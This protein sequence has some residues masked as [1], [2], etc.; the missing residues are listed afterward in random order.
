M[1]SMDPIQ[2]VLEILRRAPMTGTNKLGLLL[3]LLDLAHRQTHSNP[4]ISIE[5]LS[6][7]YLALHWEHGRPYAQ[8]P[9]RQTYARSRSSEPNAPFD[10]TVMQQ[11]YH[12]RKI[13]VDGGM[14]DLQNRNFEVVRLGMDKAEWKD[15]WEMEIR[16]S[17][18]KIAR[19]VWRNPV[20]RL[21]NLPGG[22][23]PFLF[24]TL[25]NTIKFLP[26]VATEL[27]RF[28]GVLRPLIELQFARVVG[29]INR[30]ELCA[31]EVDIHEHL[32]GRDRLMPPREIREGLIELQEGKCLFTGRKLTG[33]EISV[34][35]MI[36]WSRNRLSCVENFVVT[37][38]KV[39]E[40]KSDSLLGPKLVRKW[41]RFTHENSQTM[42]Q[43]A[44]NHDWPTDL[45]R[46]RFI[47][48]QIYRAIDP[49]F[50]VWEGRAGIGPLGESRK[51]EVIKLL[52]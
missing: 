39:N 10:T 52:Q 42:E 1:A 40:K 3:V 38:T 45:K 29:N 35:H 7:Q 31:P 21:Q 15:D 26:G 36:P 46:V 14:G 18:K 41:Y 50:V 27:T 4:P 23:S 37:T 44:R 32:F 48:L 25:K 2:G 16:A 24:C 49:A 34:D 17:L 12:L 28:A 5:E 19:D 20:K 47:A 51:E 6:A 22:P 9:L 33:K 8:F 11:V 43:L 30:N 13:L